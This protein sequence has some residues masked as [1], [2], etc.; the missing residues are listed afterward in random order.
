M[1]KNEN[2]LYNYLIIIGI[3]LIA[4]SGYLL[5]RKNG[6]FGNNF[7][8]ELINYNQLSIENAFH[9]E[10]E[11]INNYVINQLVF[12]GSDSIN[13]LSF[14]KFASQARI[15]FYF[16]LNTCSPCINKAIDLIK[17]YFPLYEKDDRIVFISPDF[18]SRL[19]DNCY[20]K[21]LLILSMKKLDIE[22][23]KENVPFFFTL[24]T[25]LMIKS[26]HVITKVDFKRTEK[27]LQT[28][29]NNKIKE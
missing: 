3:I 11:N 20:G 24:D 28:A 25:N 9:L 8:S 16:P 2:N 23:E 1:I 13:K 19:R 15:Y 26:I 22:L 12:L 21:K 4:I 18:P 7:K 27:F 17:H 6:V 5:L 10:S 29:L 14:Q